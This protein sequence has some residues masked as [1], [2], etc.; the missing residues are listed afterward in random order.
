MRPQDEEEGVTGL[1]VVRIWREKDRPG[2]RARITSSLDLLSGDETMT[3]AATREEVLAAAD[4]W[5]RR[6]LGR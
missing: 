6:F 3:T 5:L 4:E 2:V 1:L